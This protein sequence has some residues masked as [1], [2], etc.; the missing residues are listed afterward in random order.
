MGGKDLGGRDEIG[1][2]GLRRV[3]FGD[4]DEQDVIA[5]ART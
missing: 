4:R 2:E 5:E 1:I 3:Q